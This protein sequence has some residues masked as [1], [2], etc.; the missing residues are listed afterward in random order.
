MFLLSKVTFTAF[1][2]L[3]ASDSHVDPVTHTV[4]YHK[5]MQACK[6]LN[7]DI[8]SSSS[9]T[10]ALISFDV[11]HNHLVRAPAAT[12]PPPRM[13]RCKSSEMFWGRLAHNLNYKETFIYLFYYSLFLLF[14][15]ER[16][17][18]WVRV[19]KETHNNQT[20]KKHG[21]RNNKISTL[22]RFWGFSKHIKQPVL[23]KSSA[24]IKSQWIWRIEGIQTERGKKRKK[25]RGGSKPLKPQNLT[26]T[27]GCAWRWFGIVALVMDGGRDL[28]KQW[29]SNFL[30][31]AHLK[32][33][34][35]PMSQATADNFKCWVFHPLKVKNINCWCF[36]LCNLSVESHWGKKN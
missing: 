1:S 30:W 14:F 18:G 26:A 4:R 11:T 7:L 36:V 5:L 28:V 9:L 29:F 2:S 31:H 32:N 8:I 33:A 17:L 15:W 21:L 25:K 6:W 34:H 20:N 12:A 27:M 22:H 10:V 3:S 16:L 19:R 35:G 23:H 24:W 13:L